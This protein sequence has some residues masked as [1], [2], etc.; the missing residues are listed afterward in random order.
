MSEELSY[1]IIFFKVIEK[2]RG[3]ID[4]TKLLRLRVLI[5][6]FPVTCKLM[7]Y[8]LVFVLENLV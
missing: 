5:H 1:F 7:L 6:W 4:A 8:L 3:I 2:F